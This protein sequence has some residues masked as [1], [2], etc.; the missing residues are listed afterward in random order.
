MT[1]ED[2]PSD[3]WGEIFSWLNIFDLRIM[4]LVCTY[5]RSVSLSFGLEKTTLSI[6][7]GQT[8]DGVASDHVY[9]F[10]NRQRLWMSTFFRLPLPC[11]VVAAATFN[12][13]LFI[14]GYSEPG[15]VGVYHVNM[16]TGGQWETLPGLPDSCLYP[17]TSPVIYNSDLAVVTTD[18]DKSQCLLTCT[19]RRLDRHTRSWKTVKSL[20][21][22]ISALA[23]VGGKLYAVFRHYICDISASSSPSLKPTPAKTKHT[24]DF[25]AAVVVQNCIYVR[26]N[27]TPLLYVFDTTTSIWSVVKQATGRKRIGYSLAEHHGRVYLIGGDTTA[28][29]PVFYKKRTQPKV[30][31]AHPD[32]CVDSYD[33][34]A[35]QWRVEPDLPAG[36]AVR[37]FAALSV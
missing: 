11:K 24:P 5:F 7:G 28:N 36:F 30:F 19:L 1:V 22:D 21:N 3:C 16:H 8:P 4:R 26:S 15:K 35:A 18:F 34:V 23:S 10:K 9:I 12:H 13:H 29:L 20:P 31:L 27:C 37:T 2:L 32:T 17:E 25:S 6:L 14:T 33:H